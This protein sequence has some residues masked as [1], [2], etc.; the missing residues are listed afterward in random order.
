MDVT[1]YSCF[2]HHMHATKRRRAINLIA[3]NK[4]GKSIMNILLRKVD[5]P[6][7]V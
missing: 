7:K 2:V 4:K 5:S 3:L 1:Y 6:F